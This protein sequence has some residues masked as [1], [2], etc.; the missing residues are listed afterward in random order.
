MPVVGAS[1][2]QNFSFYTFVFSLFVFCFY[3]SRSN[4][5]VDANVQ[6]LT[7]EESDQ[8]TSAVTT[9][10]RPKRCKTQE[11]YECKKRKDA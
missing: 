9:T 4:E 6:R 7:K 1:L 2:F 8:C 11:I 3:R 5:R 10:I